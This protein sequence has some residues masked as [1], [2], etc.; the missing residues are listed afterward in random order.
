VYNEAESIEA[1]LLRLLESTTT[2]H[3]INVVYDFPEDTTKPLL[4]RLSKDYPLIKPVMNTYGRGPAN[5]IKYGI[6][7][8]QEQ[9]V[10]V[11]M[12]DG[13]DDPN[14]IDSLVKLVDRGVVV[15]CAS[16]YARSGQQVGGPL[17]KSF[18]SRLAGVS[19]YWLARVGTRDATNSFK[20][21]SRGF[22][23]SVGIESKYGFEIG[24]EMV[25]KARRHRQ[26]VAEIPTIWLDRTLGESNFKLLAWLLHYLRWYVYAFG[27]RKTFDQK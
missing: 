2:V 20:A 10:V 21:Y 14:Q 24:I 13:C 3:E 7:H 18:A 4:E 9:I 15:A 25:S 5:A 19:L 22:V 26:P 8:S 23:S 12:A 17:V 27:R 11:T 6:D 16:R 1:V